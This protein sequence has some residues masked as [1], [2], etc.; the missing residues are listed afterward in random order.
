MKKTH[1]WINTSEGLFL[2]ASAINGSAVHEYTGKTDRINSPIAR[3]IHGVNVEFGAERLRILRQRICADYD[4]SPWDQNL[5]K[6]CAKRF[7]KSNNLNEDAAKAGRVIDIGANLQFDQSSARLQD[8]TGKHFSHKDALELCV[9]L[10][11]E[12][13]S[14]HSD[15]KL[16][17]APRNVG[18]L[19]LDRSG[20]LLAA[21]VN[22]NAS[23]Q[24]RHAEVNL[25]LNLRERGIHEIPHGAQIYVSLKPCRMCASL[26]LSSALNSSSIKIIA[27]ADDIGSFGRHNFLSGILKIQGT[28]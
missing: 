28:I 5:I 13:K 7:C 24:M 11:D 8:M 14:H 20:K 25:M 4:I 16:H 6:V 27:A 3:L 26:I 18:A 17:L 9:S 21:N 15:V 19:I 22:T 23:S 2:F 10:T 1:A 12:Q